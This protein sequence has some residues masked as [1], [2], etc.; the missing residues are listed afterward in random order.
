MEE[1]HRLKDRGRVRWCGQEK[2]SRINIEDIVGKIVRREN[3]V[4]ESSIAVK[5]FVVDGRK[6]IRIGV[7]HICG[8][9]SNGR[10]NGIGVVYIF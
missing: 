4:I 1:K 9:G 2:W 3:V 7:L 6:V 8:K 10:K 5:F